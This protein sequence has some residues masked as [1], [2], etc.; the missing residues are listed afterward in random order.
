MS[1]IIWHVIWHHIPRSSVLALTKLTCQFVL[2][3]RKN[4]QMMKNSNIKPLSSNLEV[5]RKHMCMLIAVT[6]VFNLEPSIVM[7]QKVISSTRVLLNLIIDMVK[8]MWPPSFEFKAIKFYFR[9]S[10]RLMTILVNLRFW[11]IPKILKIRI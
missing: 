11:Q 10:Q 5:Q 1:H 8:G 2:S 4:F 9:F 6:M 7:W 3:S